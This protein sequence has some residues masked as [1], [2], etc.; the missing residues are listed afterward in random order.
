MKKEFQNRPSKEIENISDLNKILRGADRIYVYPHHEI[1][2]DN[3]NLKQTRSGPNWEGGVVTMATCKHLLRTYNSLTGKTVICGLTNKL[4]GKNFLMYIGMID[5]TFDSNLELGEYLDDEVFQIKCA[6]G[7]RLGDIFKPIDVNSDKYDIFN[8]EE[9]TGN[10]CRAEE[11]DSKGNPK[12]WKDIEYSSRG[13]IR[14]KCLIL[15]PVTVHTIPMFSW[16][17]RLGRSGIVFKGDDC[18]EQ[19]LSNLEEQL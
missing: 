17:G 1:K 8:F 7:N 10:H 6:N 3:G 9:P 19:F 14:P 2:L 13:G 5:K 15:N 16:E 18:V 11:N 4:E 12:W